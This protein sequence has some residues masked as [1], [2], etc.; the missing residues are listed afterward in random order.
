MKEIDFAKQPWKL[1]EFAA[2]STEELKEWTMTFDGAPII[3]T[4]LKAG[5]PLYFK[6]GDDNND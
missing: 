4:D 6:K 2:K 3:I 5:K 1:V